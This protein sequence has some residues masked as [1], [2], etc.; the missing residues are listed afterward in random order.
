MRKVVLA[1][2]MAAGIVV[3]SPAPAGAWFSYCEW[4]P[5]V[6]VVTPAGHVV[7]LYDSVWTPSPL[8]LG[9]PLATTSVSRVY[10]ST[11]QPETAVDTAITVPTGL[12]SRYSVTDEVTTGLLGSGKVLAMK[13]GTSG[14]TLHLKFVLSQA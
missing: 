7:L 14:Q 11:G 4:D 6:P 1:A 3:F 8:D 12:L 9:V 13:S 10:S 5:L 2:L